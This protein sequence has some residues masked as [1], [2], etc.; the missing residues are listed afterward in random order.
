MFK[1]AKSKGFGSTLKTAIKSSVKTKEWLQS[2][3]NMTATNAEQSI[4]EMNHFWNILHEITTVAEQ[5]ET[6]I[7]R[8]LNA[9]KRIN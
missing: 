6:K 5:L 8:K 1:S 4:Q 2:A 3:L 9:N 7:E